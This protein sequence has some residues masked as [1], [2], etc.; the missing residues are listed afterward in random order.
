MRTNVV[1][2]LRDLPE[3]DHFPGPD[4]LDRQLR[5]LHPDGIREIGRSALGDPIRMVTVGSGERQALVFAGPHPNEPVGFLTVRVLAELLRDEPSLTTDWTWHLVGCVDPDGARLN[6]GWYRGPFTRRNYVRQLYRPPLH[7]QVEWTFPDPEAPTAEGVLPE[8]EALRR[9]ID[10]I[11]PDLMCSLHNREFGGMFCYLTDELPGLADELVAIAVEAGL[12]LHAGDAELPDARRIRPGVF[13]VPTVE[14]VHAVVGGGEDRPAF[15]RSSLHYAARHGTVSLVTE[16]PMWPDARG[17]SEEPSGRSLGEVLAEAAAAL[18]ETPGA[19]GACV[20][21]VL[22]PSDCR[23]A[24][25]L[26]D[27]RHTATGLAQALGELAERTGEVGASVA[28][29]FDLLQTVHMFRLR[30]AGTAL[31]IIDNAGAAELAPA[32]EELAALF[33][34]WARLADDHAYATHMPLRDLAAVQV[35]T[36]LAAAGAVA[37]S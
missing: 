17:G 11:R 1:D 23:F 5:E 24:S 6:E 19:I 26:T 36:V 20:D 27:L 7:E 9:V 12:P 33:D 3:F 22:P 35:R 34:G 15:G 30:G 16:V 28:D 37:A 32:R 31:R 4:D 29:E 21:G 25:S 18:A 8:T 13:S 10:E 14:R 2:W